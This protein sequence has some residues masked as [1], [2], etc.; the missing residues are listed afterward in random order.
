MNM[1]FQR[2]PASTP[3]TQAGEPLPLDVRR[4][5]RHV[6]STVTIITTDNGKPFG[7]VATAMMSLSLEP[8]AL[9]IGIN[10]SA[11]VCGPLLERQAFCVNILSRHDDDIS[12]RF[13]KLSGAAR[14]SAGNWSADES[15]IFRGIP[16]LATAQAAL[17]CTVQQSIDSGTHS[18]IVG[19]I[20]RAID[21]S[22]DDPLL[23]CDGGYGQFIKA[24]QS[25]PIALDD[26]LSLC[27]S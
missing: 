8:P 25:T 11:S 21:S 7:M 15:G 17:F 24:D 22:V 5:M 9:A 6:G 10:H 23:Y 3:Q 4:V 16:F 18:L 1:P 20:L 26:R 2:T 19:S 27:K 13:T 14:F 12:R